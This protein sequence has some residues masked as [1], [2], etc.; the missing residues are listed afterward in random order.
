MDNLNFLSGEDLEK[1]IDDTEENDRSL[2][3]YGRNAKDYLFP[4]CE[5]CGAPR[6]V[7]KSDDFNNCG[8]EPSKDDLIFIKK[9]LRECKGR[10]KK[11]QKNGIFR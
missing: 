3:K 10:I 7:Q 6:I 11:K 5:R 9:M 2:K 4:E 8:S 1:K